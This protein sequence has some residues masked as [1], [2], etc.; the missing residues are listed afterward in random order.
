M[1]SMSDCGVPL[2]PEN[3][4]DAHLE[5]GGGGGGVWVNSERIRRGGS[6]PGLRRT[7]ILNARKSNSD[8]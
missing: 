3:G 6:K 8:Y 7:L 1:F 5:E 4:G 2:F